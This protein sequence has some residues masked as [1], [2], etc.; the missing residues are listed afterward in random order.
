M[1]LNQ[2]LDK[3]HACFDATHV[4]NF[5][6]LYHF[7]NIASNAWYSKL[8]NG[9]WTG[10]IV[11]I[12]SGFYFTPVLS[13]NRSANGVGGTAGGPDRPDRNTATEIAAA[14]CPSSPTCNYAAVPYNPATVI[15]G[16]PTQWFNPYMF[17][18]GTPGYFGN[19]GRDSLRGPGSGTWNF[20]LVK[21]TRLPFLGEAGNLEFRAE[22]FNVLNRAN[23]STPASTTIFGG[24]FNLATG[25]G[26]PAFAPTASPSATA[27]QILTTANP[28]RQ[29]QLALKIL[30]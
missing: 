12:N 29:I 25:A 10:N 19:A 16:N 21:D 15:T 4:A 2:T 24:S 7:P 26:V 27:G 18:Q 23:F 17:N 13:T 3:G 30:F 1:P 14:G 11:S 6:L 9:W 20:S 28:S 22:V 5:N 8:T